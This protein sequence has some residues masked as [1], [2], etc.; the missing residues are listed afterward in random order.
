MERQSAFLSWEMHKT[1]GRRK[2][3]DYLVK[4][5]LQT[6]LPPVGRRKITV[7][8]ENSWQVISHSLRLLEGIHWSPQKASAFPW[9]LLHHTKYPSHFSTG[10]R[11]SFTLTF[12]ISPELLLSFWISLLSI[13]FSLLSFI[14]ALLLSPN[15]YFVSRATIKT[16]LD[17]C[18]LPRLHVV[19][20]Q[21]AE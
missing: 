6:S 14:C 16:D 7:H 9:Q 21:N 15:I 19:F 17:V 18:P 3:S 10:L 13:R 1:P 5:I 8:S 11:H 2:G 4:E 20:H 12:L